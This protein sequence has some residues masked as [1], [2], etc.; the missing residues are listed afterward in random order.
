MKTICDKNSW[1]YD[2]NRATASRLIDI[3]I[4]NGL[5]QSHNQAV[6]NNL[7]A[8]L[9]SGVPTVRN[10]NGGHGQ[11]SNVRT[12]PNHIAE[13]CLDLTASTIKLLVSSD[14]N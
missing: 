12:V 13:Y 11:G 10:R 7:Q 9:K 6:L 2:P 14:Q 4:T 5:I 3:C 1:I 8:I